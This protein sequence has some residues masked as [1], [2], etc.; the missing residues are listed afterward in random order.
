MRTPPEF[1]DRNQIAVLPDFTDKLVYVKSQYNPI[2]TSPIEWI[3]GIIQELAL[4]FADR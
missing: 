1:S 3:G 4:L 2:Y